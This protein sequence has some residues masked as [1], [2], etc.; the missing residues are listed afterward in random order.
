ML[1]TSNKNVT[2]DENQDKFWRLFLLFLAS[3]L[4]PEVP[5]NIFVFNTE[6]KNIV[7]IIIDKMT[8]RLKNMSKLYYI[9]I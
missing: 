1:F 3:Q 7:H 5:S 6:H 4:S 9:Q 8:K 2:V